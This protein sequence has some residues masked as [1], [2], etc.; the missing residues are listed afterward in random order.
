MSKGLIQSSR[1]HHH[2]HLCLRTRVL[3]IYAF[4]FQELEALAGIIE[5]NTCAS[6]V[7]IIWTRISNRGFIEAMNSCGYTEPPKYFMSIIHSQNST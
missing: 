2:P 7:D 4:D 6:I 3:R 5:L 1:E